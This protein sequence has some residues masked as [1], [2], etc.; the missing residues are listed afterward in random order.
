MVPALT[1]T[2]PFPQHG[3]VPAF[4][5]MCLIMWMTSGLELVRLANI[6]AV[7]IDKP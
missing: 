4:I 1:C 7:G 3:R 6:P 5:R 2:S